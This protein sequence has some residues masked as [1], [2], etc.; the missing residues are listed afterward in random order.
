MATWLIWLIVSGIFIVAEVL[1]LTFYLLLA[2]IGAV[3]AAALAY[4]G[5]GI[6]AQIIGATLVTVIGWGI[7]HKYKPQ[8]LHPDPQTNP[9]MNMDIG[10][11]IRIHSLTP[12]GKIH[13]MHRGA[14]W[15]AKIENNT[16]ADI[17]KEYVISK[18]DG[19][20][21]IINPKSSS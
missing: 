15:D 21:L 5:A 11:V 18:I 14:R 10:A 9:D 20:T 13:V 12:D 19:S 7:I 17:A 4:L 2:G 3:V 16:P 6:T 8:N 1:T